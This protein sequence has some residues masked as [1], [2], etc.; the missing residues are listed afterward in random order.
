[1]AS[2]EYSVAGQQIA[3]TKDTELVE[4]T[5]GV[6]DVKFTFDSSW[7]DFTDKTAVF[8]SD[9]HPDAPYEVP[10][11]GNG[12]A[13]IPAAVIVFGN[14][15]I[16][17][18]GSTQTQQYPTVWAPAKRVWP[19]A[20]PGMEP[21]EDPVFGM[22]VRTAP[23]ELTEEQQEIARTNIGAAPEVIPD[24]TPGNI[25]IIDTN[26][27][28]QDSG[29]S[30]ADI[31]D[32]AMI[33]K[34]VS[35]DI[36][37][38]ED[39]ADDVP[40]KQMTVQIEPI[41]EGTGDPSP[42]NVRAISGWTGANVYR[43]KVNMFDEASATVYHRYFKNDNTWA[44]AGDSSSYAFPCRPN[45][46]YNVSQ[47]NNNSSLLRVAYITTELPIQTISPKMYSITKLTQA[48]TV[49]ITTG[50]N[51]TYIVIQVNSAL[52]SNAGVQITLDGTGASY[53]AYT[54]TTYEIEFP[55]TAGTVYGGELTVNEDGTGVLTV[56]RAY[57]DL[58]TLTWSRRATN[59]FSASLPSSY[60]AT[61]AANQHISNRYPVRYASTY[62]NSQTAYVNLYKGTN[63]QTDNTVYLRFTDVD[64]VTDLATWFTNN[65]TQLCYFVY[66][67]S[68][69]QITAEQM[70]TLLGLNNIWADTG[71]I[72]VT[73][74]A[75][76]TLATEEQAKAIKES[77]APVEDGYT[78]SQAYAV[79]DLVYVDDTLYI[80]TSAIA[81]GAT[82]TPNT[83]ISATTLNTVIKSLR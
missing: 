68:T 43:S 52:A 39:G 16:G 78:A 1:M 2:I 31:Y 12:E 19:G 21:P 29:K 65:P 4:N 81:S 10:L 5:V 14:L 13:P 17:V 11:D 48:G 3:V 33:S 72:S 57:A 20:G 82:M 51:A 28:I 41:Q 7:S 64:S 69:Y 38:I 56:D 49:R 45:T 30:L 75:D 63:T 32:S 47:F 15:M 40:I 53:E 9:T 61:V 70:T 8:V 24:S 55:D 44:Y 83:N 25:T 18:Y 77:I 54:G 37:T 79:N 35:G 60:D 66:I 36:V 42:S 23:Q 76:P 74:R 26:R 34:T 22:V 6:Y 80:V 62:G 50:N 27:N 71:D 46:V 73:Y 59:V 67:K 58:A